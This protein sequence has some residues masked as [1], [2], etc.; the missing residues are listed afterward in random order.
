MTI[1][2]CTVD[3]RDKIELAIDNMAS[4]PDVIAAVK[5]IESDTLKT[6]QDNYGRYMSILSPFAESGR[7]MLYIMSQAMIRAGGNANGIAW[8]VKLL[9]G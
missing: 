9:V 6:T 8:A 7:T 4:D 2:E 3:Q 1:A 5:S